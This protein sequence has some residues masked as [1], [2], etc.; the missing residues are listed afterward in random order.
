MVR[1][2]PYWQDGLAVTLWE[3]VPPSPARPTPGRWVDLEETCR[4]PAEWDLAV[5]TGQSGGADAAL[6]GYADVAGCALPSAAL[7]AP[8]T[9]ARQLEATVW[10]LCMAHRYPARYREVARAP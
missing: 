4:G 1:P 9:R 7:L 3:F 8:F 6:R 10:A 2:G 5:L